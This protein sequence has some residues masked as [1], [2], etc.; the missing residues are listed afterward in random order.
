MDIEKSTSAAT[1]TEGVSYQTVDAGYLAER[2][3][4]KSA[5]WVLLWA[6]GV[7]AV[8]SGEFFGWNFGLGAGGFGGLGIATVVVAILYI[9]LIFSIAELSAALPHAGGFYSFAR[10]A[11]GPWGGYVVGVTDT[12]EYVLTPAVIVVAIGG[13]LNTLFP[14]ISV[15]VWWV[16]AYAGFVGINVKGVELTLKVGLVVTALAMAVLVVYF[17]AAI[18]SGAFD[19]ALL[20]NIVGENGSTFLPMGVAGIFAAI[21][22]AVWFFLAIEQLP[23]AAEEAHDVVRDMPKAMIWGLFTLFALGFGVLV[24][25]TGVGGGAV[26][27]KGS[28]SPLA[29]GFTAIF[30]SGATTTILTLVALTGLVASF[31]TVIYAYGRVIF[32]L[33]RSGYYPRFLSVTG[34]STR[35]PH[36]AL[37]AGAAIGLV[38][39]FMIA[40]LG[41]GIVGAALL[42]M[43]VFGAVIS[44]FLVLV[45]FLV[46]RAKRP[47]MNRPYKSPLGV[48]GA[49]VGAALSLIA[50]VATLADPAYRPGVYGVAIWLLVSLAWF[51]FYSRKRLVA[52]APEEEI[53]LVKKAEA[54]LAHT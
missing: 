34:T 2:T 47:E 20:F 3:L 22:Y 51:G 24:L 5:G 21:P 26:A 25:N 38:A 27:L 4:K 19:P 8:I 43:A 12:I 32:A 6:L 17:A 35:T 36:R 15:Y 28:A 46:L 50:L 13:Y 14:A 16:V 31:H 52:N 30:G 48:A 33:S 41:S 7:G 37:I 44:Y 1:T 42:N 45:S 29:D 10:Q 23:L 9:C 53:A 54:D 39:A 40:K 11:L 49:W 18:F